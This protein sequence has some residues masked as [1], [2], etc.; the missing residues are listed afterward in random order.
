[1]EGAHRRYQ[2]V[3]PITDRNIGRNLFKTGVSADTPHQGKREIERR[4]RQ[5]A[6]AAARKGGQE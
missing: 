5:Q 3:K 6:R 4:L 1:M 2:R